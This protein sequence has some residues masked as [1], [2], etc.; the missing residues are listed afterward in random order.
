MPEELVTTE[1]AA[2]L[3]RV[4]QKTVL[5]L[6]RSGRLRADKVGRSWRLRRS[7]LPC[8][9]GHV[10]EVVYLD[11]NASNPIDPVVLDAMMEV[12][13]TQVGN[14]SSSHVIGQRSR[15]WVERARE[16][17]AALLDARPAEVVF[18]S[19]ATEANNLILNGF[20]FDG[21]RRRVLVSAGE[22]ASVMRAAEAV[23]A[24][25][26]VECAVVPLLPSGLVDVDALSALL[27]AGDVGLVSIVAANSET[28]VLNPIQTLS[29]RVRAAGAL[30]HCDA[31]QWVGRLPWS[32]EVLGVDAVSISGHKMCGPQGVGGLL[33]RRSLLRQLRPL[34]VGGGHEAGLRSGSY[35][36][37]GIVGLG[38]AAELA[39][40]KGDATQMAVLRDRLVDRLS[41]VGGV[42]VNGRG[43]DRLPNTA[44]V[45]FEGAPG[46]AVL[47]RS[48]GVAASLGSAC[49]AGSLE[50]SPTLLAMGL[51]REAA[52]ESIRFSVSRFTTT[53]GVDRAAS[54]VT[55]AVNE[56]RAIGQVA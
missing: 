38:A 29:D 49:H 32:M 16:K 36:V 8:L 41:K 17:L 5:R 27:E 53:A 7:D 19:G 22:H 24:A 39:A 2:A 52:N 20:P 12:W 25:G 50:P 47:A 40:R 54:I 35:N 30:L 43:V 34:L 44:N 6:I 4:S 10:D 51:D 13:S 55:G 28:G 15:A 11:D 46:D 37:A 3:L 21:V 9:G 56:V 1:E 31:T 48:T 45:R 18:T 42:D 33:G 14:A 23:M 26:R